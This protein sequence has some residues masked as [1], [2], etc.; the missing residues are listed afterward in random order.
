LN[1]SRIAVGG[2]EKQKMKKGAQSSNNASKGQITPLSISQHV[3]QSDGMNTVFGESLQQDNSSN[4][5]E[6]FSFAPGTA[7]HNASLR[8]SR[9]GHYKQSVANN[10]GG[11]RQ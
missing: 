3:K 1:S 10:K 7:E 4:N 9:Q 8:I 6:M 11:V 5:I 2:E